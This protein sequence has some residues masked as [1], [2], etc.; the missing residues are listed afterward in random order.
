MKAKRKYQSGGKLTER[1]KLSEPTLSPSLKKRFNDP[2]TRQEAHD[3]MVADRNRA[4]AAQ[5]NNIK[6]ERGLNPVYPEFILPAAKVA[7]T[8]FNIAKKAPSLLARITPAV[9]PAIRL[10][11][12]LSDIY[13]YV[14]PSFQGGGMI[15]RKDGSYSKRGLWDNIRKNIGS[16]KKPTKAMLKAEKKINREG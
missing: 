16:G 12:N 7:S 9:Y 13:E 6:N 3:K 15:K 1:T 14:N 2:K 5:W 11:E 4:A 8:G 10:T